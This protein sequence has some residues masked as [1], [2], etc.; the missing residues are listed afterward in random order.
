MTSRS[1]QHRQRQRLLYEAARLMAEDGVRDPE[2]ARRKA[3]ARLGIQDSR[4][5]P[6][7][8][9]IQAALLQQQRLFHQDQASHLRALRGVA[10]QAMESFARFQPRLVGSVLDGSAD[11]GGRVRLHVFA[12]AP[13]E[14]LHRLL[15]Q[16]IPWQEGECLLP[17]GGGVRRSYPMLRF[18]A[19]GVGIDLV[20]LPPRAFSDPPFSPLTER[21]ER[22][23]GIEQVRALLD[24][25]R[26][27][28]ELG[29]EDVP[30][31]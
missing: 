13:D 8:D 17:H 9:E 6:R 7:N 30:A 3:A 4:L 12:E 23:A 2:Q 28:E 5:W 1:N 15:E 20:V 25:G 31:R 14:V 21:P 19:G 16:G 26:L 11:R 24:T 27:S 18:L 10:L 29:G 22:G